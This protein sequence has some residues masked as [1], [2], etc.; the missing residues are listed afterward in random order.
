[1]RQDVTGQQSQFREPETGF[2][3]K[4]KLAMQP[5]H[6]FGGQRRMLNRPAVAIDQIAEFGA[7]GQIGGQ[8]QWLGI[9]RVMADMDREGRV[10]GV[11]LGLAG[12]E[13]QPGCIANRASFTGKSA[14]GVGWGGGKLMGT[15]WRGNGRTKSPYSRGRPFALGAA[16]DSDGRCNCGPSVRQSVAP[17]P[18][19]AQQFQTQHP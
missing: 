15:R 11:D 5:D 10:V 3:G 1:M 19:V 16:S 18:R 9:L 8:H 2:G 13:R 7:E 17:W 4:D 12:H 14:L 6:L